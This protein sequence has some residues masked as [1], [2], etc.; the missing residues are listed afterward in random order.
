[1]P[2]SLP[3]GI[4]D[5]IEQVVPV[6]QSRGLF[7]TEYQGSTLREHLGLARPVHR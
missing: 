1:M 6:L 5:F 4:E 3:G 7:R 2:P